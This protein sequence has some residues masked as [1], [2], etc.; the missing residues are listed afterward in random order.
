MCMHVKLSAES[1]L[2][3]LAAVL[4]GRKRATQPEQMM[5]KARLYEK[6]CFEQ[7]QHNTQNQG[8]AKK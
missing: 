2:Q 6:A 7:I 8:A 4:P 3:G 5:P 1:L